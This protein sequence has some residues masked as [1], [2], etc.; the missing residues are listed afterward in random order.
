MVRAYRAAAGDTTWLP[1][2]PGM[3]PGLEEAPEGPAD[4][5]APPS[6]SAPGT[7]LVAHRAG[8]TP[9]SGARSDAGS[10]TSALDASATSSQVCEW[11]Q[12]ASAP[13]VGR[14]QGA[15]ARGMG[16]STV[17]AWEQACHGHRA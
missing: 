4:L 1:D 6:R 13:D 9:H 7:P 8:A 11:K 2:L 12:G 3:G 5:D 16:T 10:D 14:R 17:M 15:W